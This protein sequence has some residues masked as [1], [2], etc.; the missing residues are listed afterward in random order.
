MAKKKFIRHSTPD[1]ADLSMLV[2]MVF[3]NYF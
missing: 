1:I 3:V 2:P